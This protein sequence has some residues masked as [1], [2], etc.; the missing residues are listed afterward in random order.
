MRAN[1]PAIDGV[2]SA[3]SLSERTIEL[4]GS[5]DTGDGRQS[6][7]KPCRRW[8]VTEFES[9]S[10]DTRSMSADTQRRGQGDLRKGFKT[11]RL[12]LLML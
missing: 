10:V 5:E 6:H 12:L 1:D 7:G 11:E 3:L 8:T 4:G 9:L 2:I